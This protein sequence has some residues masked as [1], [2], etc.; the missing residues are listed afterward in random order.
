MD[1]ATRRSPGADPPT[2]DHRDCGRHPIVERPVS[3]EGGREASAP[4][5]VRPGRR[6]GTPSGAT[7][8]ERAR[9]APGTA[10]VHPG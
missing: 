4:R 5:R 7:A 3:T 6:A 8:P 10:G 9:R 1:P 2:F